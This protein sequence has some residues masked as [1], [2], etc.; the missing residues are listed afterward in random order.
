M[1]PHREGKAS[2]RGRRPYGP[3][4]G[5][6]VPTLHSWPSSLEPALRG[7]AVPVLTLVAAGAIGGG[8]SLWA[9]PGRTSRS[10]SGCVT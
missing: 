9:C 2:G 3:T 8:E 6:Y 10:R 1:S 4:P 7:V 5:R